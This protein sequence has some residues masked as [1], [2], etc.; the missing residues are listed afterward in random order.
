MSLMKS[1]C[2]FLVAAAVSASV[3]VGWAAGVGPGNNVTATDQDLPDLGSPATAA[4]SQANG[5]C[6]K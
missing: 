3:G 6:E 1:L 5:W 4:V 2:A